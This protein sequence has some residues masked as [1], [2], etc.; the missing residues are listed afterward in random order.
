MATRSAD[1]SVRFRNGHTPGVRYASG[2]VVVDELLAGGRLCSR[3]WSACGQVWPETHLDK[4]RYDVDEPADSFVLDIDGVDLGG[5][6]SWAGAAKAPDTSGYRSAGDPVTVGRVTLSHSSGIEV[7]V[8]TR[9]DGSAF[10]IRWLE[11]TNR[12]DRAAGITAVCP[13]SGLLWSHRYDEHLPRGFDVP[14]QLGYNHLFAWGQEGDFWFEPLPDGTKTVDGGKLG[15]SGWGRPAFWARNVCTGQTVV[16]ELAWGGNYSFTLDCRLSA[17]SRQGKLFFRMGLSG[18]DRV[19]RVLSPGETVCTPPVHL[20]FFQC[21]T[22]TI[23]RQTH[24]HVR[25]VIMPEQIPGR[26]VEIEANHRGYLCD[27]ENE[28]ELKRDIE[29]AAAIGAEMYVVDAGWYGNDP[30]TWWNNTGDWHAGSWLPNGLEPVVAHAKKLGMRFGLWVEIEAAG[31]NSTLRKTHPDWLLARNGTPIN[32]RALDLTKP[33]VAR[34]A[35]AEI[36]RIVE[37]Y[38]LDLYRIDHN[39]TLTPSGNR[40]FQGHTEDLTWRYYE[41]LYGIFDR[42]RARLPNVVFQNC[43]GGG[44]RLDWGTLR[45]FHNTE[46]SDWM[47]Q[48]RGLRILNGAT[49]SLPP[50]VLLRTFGTEVGE[51]ELDGDVDAQLRMVC[52]CRPIFRGIAPS[53]EELTPYLR[54]RIEHHLGL[55]RSVIRPLMIGGTVIHHTPFQP[56]FAD[57]P[58]CVLEYAAPDGRS[59]VAG[60][61]RT[62]QAGPAEYQLVP[63]GLDVSS[64]FDVTLDNTGKTTRATG[65]ELANHG[66]RIRVENTMSSELVI[67]QAAHT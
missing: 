24:E 8:C 61:F 9:L 42:L 13:W 54:E 48:P 19:L 38:G 40:V 4:L 53:L 43:A 41:A 62:S 47:R 18:Q 34:W 16:C 20:G 46:L 67:F 64:S 65:W 22:D 57:A 10:L 25:H 31:A 60:L 58:W 2:P 29:V 17:A 35:E 39:H 63:R 11:I 59:A 44:G 7:T 1:A 33:E 51:H 28:P 6:Y 56:V 12:R 37:R 50:E 30:N 27:R 55:Y 49:L 66:L 45:R 21:D 36:E 23:V 26:H 32:G 3:Y 52:L 14:F 5:E 15:R